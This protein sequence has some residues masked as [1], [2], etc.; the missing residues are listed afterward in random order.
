MGA[1]MN[2]LFDHMTVRSKSASM[3][4]SVSKADERQKCRESNRQDYNRIKS[5]IESDSGSEPL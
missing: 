3:T 1:R 2:F 4:E 5:E